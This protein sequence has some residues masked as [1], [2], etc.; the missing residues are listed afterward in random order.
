V[1]ALVNRLR[2][3]DPLM[4][5]RLLAAALAIVAIVA[6][7]LAGAEEGTR[8]P[9]AWAYVLAVVAMGS[10]AW[11]RQYPFTV[12]VV[13]A[14]STVTLTALG[15]PEA[16]APFAVFIAFYT[17]AAYGQ[18]RNLALS[19]SI[20]AVAMGV[21]W[22]TRD[23]S[24]FTAGDFVAN[25]VVFSIAWVLGDTIRSRRE[26]LA[27]AEDRARLLEQEQAETE[28]RVLAEERLRIA[29]ELHDVVAHAMSVIT[30]QA[31][32]GAHVI[33]T[34]PAEAKKALTAIEAT[35]RSA[36]QELRR[37]LGLLR[38]EGDARGARQPA[39]GFEDMK[40]LI[41]SV[42]DAGVPIEE[43]WV[44]DPDI[45][46]PASIYLSGYR[47]LQE[48]LTNV[49]KH[50]GKASVVVTMTLEPGWASIEVLDDGRGA[51][52]MA[53]NG[54]RSPG[55]GY[56]LVGMRERVAVFGGT[57]EA[58]PRQGGGFRVRARFPL[59]VGASPMEQ[60]A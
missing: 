27:A 23:Q 9:D 32:V 51:A 38:Q 20:V 26:R 17:A 8:A 53:L 30:V 42:R 14:T 58:G 22:L 52:S 6:L 31:G 54:D 18:R 29:Q 25:T 16:G 5:D 55:S 11:R 41:Q 36:L 39:P 60:S 45:P 2:A 24:G 47:I 15:Y 57:L 28:R 50:A 43:R 21:L 40:Q 49:L 3:I 35:G 56:G 19:A 10:L 46:I 7:S 59:E 34:Q 13:S 48:A 44:G 4:A 1:R 12:M 37:M 33:D